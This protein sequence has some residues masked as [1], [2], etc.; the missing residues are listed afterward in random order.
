MFSNKKR[1]EGDLPDLPPIER[2][3]ISDIDE[4]EDGRNSLPSF[5]DS[6]SENG[7]S[8]A[9]IKGAVN[10]GAETIDSP[11]DEKSKKNIKI[12]EMEEWSPS[13]LGDYE[14]S[15]PVPIGEDE[16]DEK[17][18][19]KEDKSS[20]PMTRISP[21]PVAQPS[22]G[23]GGYDVSIKG[24]GVKGKSEVFVKIDRFHSARRALR[25]ANKGLKEISDLMKKIRETK[26]R[27]EQELSAWEKD[28][29]NIKARIRDVTENIF[30]KVD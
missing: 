10:S 20:E 30:E 24:S 11:D 13:E 26:L 7:F 22:P 15:E 6:P 9:A 16:P 18:S 12:V 2:S 28:V 3:S 1:S 14:E 25:D 5:P 19:V 8:Q 17:L 4:D 23:V 29:A 21:P 27:E